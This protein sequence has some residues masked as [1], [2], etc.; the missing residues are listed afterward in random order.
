MTRAAEVKGVCHCGAVTVTLRLSKPAAEAP[1]R[2]CQCAF[3]RAHG[4]MTVA[5]PGGRARIAV[6]S[7]AD[8]VRYRFDKATADFLICARCG[9][10]AAAVL[11]AGGRAWATVNVRG[12]AIPEFADRTA[13]PGDYSGESAKARIARRKAGWTPATIAFETSQA[14]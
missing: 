11:S 13:E 9:V 4:A 12:L 3:C 1:V 14:A 5:D 10:Y 7:E 8:L 2:A 6:H